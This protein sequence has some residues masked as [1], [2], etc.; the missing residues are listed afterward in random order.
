MKISG[1]LI[2][3]FVLFN[4]VEHLSSK[5]L[6]V[7]VE[8]TGVLRA[9]DN[10]IRRGDSIVEGK[11][12]IGDESSDIQILEL[13]HRNDWRKKRGNKNEHHKNHGKKSCRGI[14]KFTRRC[15]KKGG[16]SD[17]DD[18]DDDDY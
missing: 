12:I 11:E 7:E 18:D 4:L 3:S 15:R 2:W 17:E 1:I 10:A 6:L 8:E 9:I 16:G 13:N 14:K 5:Y